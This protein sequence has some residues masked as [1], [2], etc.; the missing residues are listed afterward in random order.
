MAPKDRIVCDFRLIAAILALLTSSCTFSKDMSGKFPVFP[1]AEYID[2]F[3]LD[4]IPEQK[5]CTIEGTKNSKEF[6]ASLAK[7]YPENWREPSPVTLAPSHRMV[8]G[9]TEILILKQGIAVLV[10]RG[11][12]KKVLVHDFS[13]GEA[14]ELVRMACKD[15][16]K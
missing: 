9:A 13:R 2:V 11:G 10:A 4:A 7:R 12:N 16:R 1:D 5:L 14:E 8:A 6:I 15:A 3:K